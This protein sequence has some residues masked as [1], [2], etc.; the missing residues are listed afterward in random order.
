MAKVLTEDEASPHKR[1]TSPSCQPY[2]AK[3]TDGA[4]F[5]RRPFCCDSALNPVAPTS[6]G[7]QFGP[8]MQHWRRLPALL[9][10]HQVVA[11]AAVLD[12]PPQGRRS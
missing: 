11:N 6:N 12:V 10:E 5:G 2:L 8:L 1:A 3:A 9:H 4:G 7:L